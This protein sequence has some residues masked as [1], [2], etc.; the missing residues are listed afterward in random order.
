MFVPFT[1]VPGTSSHPL[2]TFGSF[3]H[4]FAR[5]F[6]VTSTGLTRFRLDM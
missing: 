3:L 5:T 4:P 1:S 2:G 6:S